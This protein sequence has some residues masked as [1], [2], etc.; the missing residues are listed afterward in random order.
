MIPVNFKTLPMSPYKHALSSVKKWGGTFSDYMPI[1][2]L[3][4]SSKLHWASW[5]HRAIL[6]SSFG[7]ELCEQIFGD[8]LINSDGKAVEVRYICSLHIRE[9]CGFVP[10]LKDWLHDLPVKKFAVNLIKNDNQGEN[11]ES[12]Q[13]VSPSEQN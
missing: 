10:T 8:V 3:L 13:P 6:H 4:D 2:R 1:H 12:G 7:I 9:D 5:Q 11:T